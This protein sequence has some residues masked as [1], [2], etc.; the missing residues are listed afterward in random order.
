MFNE[1][2]TGSPQGTP[3]IAGGIAGSLLGTAAGMW[4]SY[5]NRKTSKYNTNQT[6]A[7]QKAESELAYQRSLQMWE[8]QNLY[9]S[10]QAQMDRFK[11]A[12]LNPHLIYGQGSAG[13]AQAPAPYQPANIQYRY[14]A[15]TYGASIQSILPTLMDVG[16]W[17]QNMRVSEAGILKT[18]TESER[19]QQMI[20][21]LQEKNP[22]ALTQMDNA[23]S[24]YPYQKAL[25]ATNAE[26]AIRTVGDMEQEYKFKWGEPLLVDEP[27]TNTRNMPN[28][29]VRKL[30][31]LQEQSKTKL[32]EAKSSWSEFD[33][34]DPQQIMMMVLNGVM[35]LAGQT[36]RLSTHKSPAKAPVRQRPRGLNYRR[37]SSNH[38]DR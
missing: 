33:I 14:Q 5:Q 38:P 10:P 27:Y 9:N 16:S 37:M 2:Y 22:R 25:Q 24:M 36:L 8:R 21:Y 15:P 13:N 31:F 23:M 30:Q 6:I 11:Q 18:R 4:D 26:K 17:M 1:G 35:G 3:G 28:S 34:T 29:G 7:A 12:G 32:L 20:E 19:S